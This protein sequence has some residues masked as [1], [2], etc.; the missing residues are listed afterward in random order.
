MVASEQAITSLE[1]NITY[2]NNIAKSFAWKYHIDED[3]IRQTL[4]VW[5][6]SKYDRINRYV[7]DE[8]TE[9]GKAHILT[10]LT[11]V[12]SGYCRKESATQHATVADDVFLYSSKHIQSMLPFIETPERWT[13]FAKGD[14]ERTEGSV[15]GDPAT[16]GNALAAYA[17]MRVA[18][19]SL[20]EVDRDVLRA[21]FQPSCEVPY[22]VIAEE[23]QVD[24]AL[25]RKRVGRAL[26]RMQRRLGGSRR[27]HRRVGESVDFEDAHVG[28]TVVGN[29][30]AQA[31]V[32]NQWGG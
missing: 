12:A 9:R 10:T 31:M 14:T 8:D 7:M 15:K 23:F 20:T 3:D 28:R 1:T 22:A 27:K 16:G 29:S 24:E 13:G 32:A 4:I 11:N 17:D 21:R 19:A 2:I 18:W 6:L 30:Q 26:S 25:V 5:W